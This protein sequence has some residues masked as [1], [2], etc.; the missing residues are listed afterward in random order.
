MTARLFAGL[1][2]TVAA[3]VLALPAS[4]APVTVNVGAALSLTGEAAVYGQS[5]KRGIDLAVQDIAKGSVSGV[6]LKVTTIDDASTSAGAAAAF[7]VFFRDGVLAIMGPTL[8]S[9]ALEVDPFA[10]GARMPVLG[11]SNTAPGITERGTFIFRPPLT[12]QFTLPR[13][14]RTVARSSLQPKTAITIVGSDAYSLSVVPI[15]TGAITAAS[16]SLTAEI[17]VPAGTT[18]FAPFA[19]Q[20][21]AADPDLVAV[22]AFP[23]EGIPLLKALRAAGYRKKIIGTDAFTTQEIITGA[24]AAANGVIVGSAWSA[25]TKTDANTKFIKAFKKKYKRTP[26][27]FAAGAYAYTHVVAHAAK[28][29]GSASQTAM[30][31]QLA[32]ITGRKR[33]TTIL[34]RFSF[35]A[36]RNGVSPVVVQ[37]IIGGKF[38]LF[39]TR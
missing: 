6:R 28:R 9:V 3:L 33:V 5:A 25:A 37:E 12:D 18:D 36:N 26:D 11:I 4:A 31:T 23:A 1:V 15:L 14:V 10:Q 35:D 30:Q 24:G 38:K 34:G 19:A 13:V 39:S 22:A 32:A 2:T 16:M 29:G 7:G 27:A 20:V 17:S 8:S 21:K